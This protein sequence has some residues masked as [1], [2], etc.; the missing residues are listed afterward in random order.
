MH[1]KRYLALLVLLILTLGSVLHAQDE[2]S[3]EGVSENQPF[4]VALTGKYPPFSFYS[5]QG[6]LQGF[7]VDVAREIARRLGR[8]S[9][10]VTTEWAGILAGLQAG[11]YDAIIGSMAITPERQKAVLFSRP[12]YIS[13]AQL[14]INEKDAGEIHSIDDLDGQSVGATLGSTYQH[15]VENNY[16]DITVRSYPG[17]PDIFQD[18]R[19]GRLQGFVTDRLVG[20]YNAKLAGEDYIP[21]G[22]LLYQERIGIPVTFDNSDLQPKINDALDAMERD[23]FLQSLH[24]KWFGTTKTFVPMLDDAEEAVPGDA[25]LFQVALTGK[26]PPFSFYNDEGELQG[27]DV[28]VAREIAR[29]LGRPC[30]IVTT[31]WAGIL[32]GLQAGRYDAII[33]SMAI[34][35]DRQKAVLFSR[36]YYISGAQLFIKSDDA[37]K[38]HSIYDLKGESVGATLGSTYQHYVEENYP[39]ITVRSYPGEPDIFQDMRS[40]RLKGFVTDRLVGQYNAKL[41]GEDYIPAGPLLYEERIGIPVTFENKDL[42]P[43]ISAALRAMESEGFLQGL[44][45]KWFGTTR[46]FVPIEDSES[47]SEQQ[48]IESANLSWG[49]IASKLLKGF[50]ITLLC[51]IVAIVCGFL[52]AI[53][54]GVGIKGAPAPF[55]TLLIIVNDFI[56]GTP[57]LVQLFFV[58]AGLPAIGIKLSPI[59]AGILT[60]TI[61]AMAYM[62]EVV[63]SGLM[64]VPQGQTTGALALGLSKLQ[65]FIHVVWPQAFRI[66]VPPLMNSV[67]ALLKDT[68]LLMVISVPEVITEAQKLISITYRPLFFYALVG[69]LFFIVAWPLMKASQRLEDRIRRKGY[70]NA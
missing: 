20:Q 43:K 17:E 42:E 53:P 59:E 65:A 56:R 19:S 68:A 69:L 11:R 35:P 54:M 55:R 34:T 13:G 66:M 12:Y 57:V 36:P 8:P 48:E 40:G 31:E 26:Y 37:D 67:V 1:P 29:R 60:L 49:L 41:A 62:A 64:A 21:V 46:T 15:Y 61:N 5:E 18:M 2:Q 28:D 32:A 10:I 27:F 22:D 14:F 45:K 39:D 38:I 4:R 3:A 51:A 7:D 6:D 9:E 16:P 30:E 58:Y 63:R 47:D 50:G 24:K 70:E 25:Q 52:L 44:H 23:G 33:G